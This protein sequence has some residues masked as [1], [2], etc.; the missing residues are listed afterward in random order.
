MPSDVLLPK[1]LQNSK[2]IGVYVA[3]KEDAQMCFAL[4]AAAAMTIFFP[5][6]LYNQA[7]LR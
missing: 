5:F 2:V 7:Y 3:K 1:F 4:Q 6:M